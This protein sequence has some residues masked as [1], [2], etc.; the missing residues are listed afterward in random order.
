MERGTTLLNG[1]KVEFGRP[2][3]PVLRRLI[4][5][6]YAAGQDALSDFNKWLVRSEEQD[7]RIADSTTA[8][9]WNVLCMTYDVLTGTSNP[10]LLLDARNATYN[11]NTK[12][13]IAQA[14]R[15]WA[16]YKSN[17]ELYERVLIWMKRK[18]DVAPQYVLDALRTTPP[19]TQ[20]EY[21][22]LLKALE[23]F[24]GS[25]RFPWGW[26][27]LRLT[28]ACGVPF[29]DIL[30]LERTK[31][32][33]ALDEGAIVLAVG[34]SHSRRSVQT[35]L[36]EEELRYLLTFPYEW[37]VLGDLIDPSKVHR[38][39]NRYR[40]TPLSRV[41]RMV[42]ERARVD[43]TSTWS[44]RMRWSAGWQ[45]YQQT[46]NLVGTS[47]ILGIR[48]LRKVS[49]FLEELKKRAAAAQKEK[50]ENEAVDV[51]TVGEDL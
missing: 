29:K 15:L 23:E 5:E 17:S 33:R 51:E 18:P 42:F 36:I 19:Y 44:S 26:P 41:A 50:E 38:S 22:R 32:Q 24:K 30:Y 39:K 37:G 25:P 7:Q 6:H 46:G 27:C 14:L 11:F 2:N 9:V 35:A 12:V 8:I 48:N 1:E 31:I 20:K 10:M 3:K 28:F 21:R 43:Y 34:S 4:K 47:Q 40:T 49:A 13:R 45:Y 16:R